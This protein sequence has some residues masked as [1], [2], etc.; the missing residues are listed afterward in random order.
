MS[1]F[2]L[3]TFLSAPRVAGLALSPDGRRLVVGAAEPD[4]KRTRYVSAL[5][6]VPLHEEGRPRRLTRSEKGD[7]AP[8]FAPDGSLLFTST[9]AI[10][11]R[12]DGL[13]PAP[14]LWRLPVAGGEPEPVACPPGGVRGCAVAEDSGDLVIATGLHAGA[15]GW[16]EDAETAKARKESETTA[17]LLTDFPVR[18]WDRWLAPRTTHLFAAAAGADPDGEGWTDLEPGVSVALELASF[19]ITPD[20]ATVVASRRREEPDPAAAR[21]DLVVYHREGDRVAM[22]ALVATDDDHADPVM[23]PDGTRVV[24]QRNER[25]TPEGPGDRTLIVV[26]LATG[27]ARDLLPAFDAFPAGAVWTRDGQHVLFTA[28]HEGH[29][30]PYAVTVA[31]G[32]VTRLAAHGAYSDLQA[33]P[34]GTVYALHAT[35]AHPPRVVALRAEV[36]DQ[37]PQVLPTPGDDVVGPGRV[38]RVTATAEDGAA[39]GSWLVRPPREASD[40][41]HGDPLAVFIHGGPVHSWNEWTW[42]WN[43]HV[44]A[45]RG[46]AV[47]LP[48]PALS[49][50]YGLEFVARGWGRW[51]AEPYTDLMAAVDAV[52]ARDDIDASRTAALGGSFGG[53][54]ANWVAGHTDRFEA[55]VTHAS[56]WDLEAFHGTTDLGVVWEREFGDPYEDPSRYRAWSPRNHVGNISTPMLVIH[57]TKD[58]RVPESEGLTLWTDLRRHEVPGAYLH[59][60]DENHWIVTPKHAR[61]WYQTVIRFLDHYVLG[62]PWQRPEHV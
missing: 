25:S 22:R 1:D 38:E 48:D 34:D 46:W 39:I 4:R 45:A 52:E 24:A 13:D 49:T 51:G 50:G 3:D 53:Y 21:S 47:L 31:D 61:I 8:R 18:F 29:R 14:W 37:E 40:A 23:A 9:R 42:R 41:D 27:E 26:D 35:M 62:A 16:S 43:P 33:A 32:T 11:D 6:E 15:T 59:F 56:L 12:D 60:P 44:L 30:L 36:P 57:G 20:G 19:A 7:A 5:Y 54:M 17:L 10:P 28:D 55:I 2:D 58:Y